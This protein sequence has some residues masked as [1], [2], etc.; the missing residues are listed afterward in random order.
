MTEANATG[1]S[2]AMMGGRWLWYGTQRFTEAEWEAVCTQARTWQVQGLHPKVADGTTRWYD[3]AGLA[4][5]KRVAEQ[6]GLRVVPYHY[7]YG[8]R[9]G[10]EQIAEEARISAWAGQVFGAVIP[11]IEDEYMGQYEAAESFGKQVRALF[12]GLWMPTLYANP[13][14]HPVPLLSLN[15]YMNAW[16]PQVYFAVWN[17][18]A[19]SAIEYVCPQWQAFD[20]QAR[21][22]G[23]A[24]LKPVLP[25]ISTSNGVQAVQIA[26]FIEKMQRYGYI[27]FWHAGTY[28]PYAR[29]MIAAPLTMIEEEKTMNNRDQL[30]AGGWKYDEQQHRWTAPNGFVVEAGFAAEVSKAWDAQD[31]PLE[32]ERHLDQLELSNPTLGEGSRQRFRLTTLEWTPTRGVFR[33][34]TGQELIELERRL[35][36]TESKAALSDAL[37]QALVNAQ[38]AIGEALKA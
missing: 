7:C 5:L 16:L 13:Q 12:A 3:D 37:H 19:Q 33:S 4:S 26:T 9:F 29:T 10:A 20:E 30:Q 25:I 21:K 6:H 27:G 14:V 28:A 35:Q 36:A 24:G 32:N 34:W 11:D 22:A 23:Q 8:P 15:P 2:L 38:N 1:R 31:Y 18:L 17:G